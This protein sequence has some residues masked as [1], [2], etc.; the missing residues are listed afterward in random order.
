VS[1]IEQTS[2]DE[3]YFDITANRS[4]PPLEIAHTIRQAI[5]QSLKITVSEGIASNKLISQI[6]SKLNK[7]AAFHTVPDGEERHFLHPLPNKWLPGVGPKRDCDG[8]RTAH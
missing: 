1:G 3:G 6:A 7:P 2:I 8:N 5:R 4:R